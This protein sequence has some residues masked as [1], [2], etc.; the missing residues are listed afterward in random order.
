MYPVHF[1]FFD[2]TKALE[3]GKVGF[4]FF[5]GFSLLFCESVGRVFWRKSA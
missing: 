5:E 3:F 2:L 1:R 4:S